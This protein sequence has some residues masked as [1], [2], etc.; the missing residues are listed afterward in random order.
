M[1]PKDTSVDRFACGASAPQAKL[2]PWLRLLMGIA[3]ILIFMFGFGHLSKWIPGAR[4]MA[5]VI[6]SRNL[7]ATAIYYTDLEEPAEA[8]AYIR[9]SLEY[10]PGS[11]SIP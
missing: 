10:G 7:R 9:D 11:G 8:S 3:L 5:E 1:I 2:N 6:D 4:R